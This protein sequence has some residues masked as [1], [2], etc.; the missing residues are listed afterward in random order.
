MLS[1][2][3]LLLTAAFVLAVG[4]TADARGPVRPAPPGPIDLIRGAFGDYSSRCPAQ[5]SYCRGT[6]GAVCC[7]FESGCC[8]DA[9]GAYCCGARASAGS[10]PYDGDRRASGAWNRDGGCASAELTCSHE[11]RTVC[12]SSSDQ[13]CAGSDGPYCCQSRGYP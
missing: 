13:C 12:C 2:R 8:E 11:G 4:C 1:Q 3:S 9:G 10:D 6:E 5:Y 7:P